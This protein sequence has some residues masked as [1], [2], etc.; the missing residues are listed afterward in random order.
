MYYPHG[1]YRAMYPYAVHPYPLQYAPRMM[2]VYSYADPFMR[3][4]QAVLGQATWT[5][6]GEVTKC[7]LSWSDNNSMTAAVGEQSPYQCGEYLHVRNLSMPDHEITVVIVDQTSGYPANKLNLH[8]KAFEALGAHVDVGVIN[9]AIT[10]VSSGDNGTNGSR[11]GEHLAA[12][13]QTA[14]PNLYV[15]GYA[16]V[17]QIDISAERTKETFEI[18]LHSPQETKKVRGN[19][20]YESDN[21]RMVSFDIE[22]M[23]RS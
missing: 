23:Q 10:P 22:E 4:Q 3:Q 20:I 1:P 16:P 5:E 21:Q 12:I 9:I 17:E 13:A 14:Y 18:T 2:P 19:V 11:W 7:G 15:G 6:G 8:R